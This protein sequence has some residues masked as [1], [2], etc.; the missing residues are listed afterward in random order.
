MMLIDYFILWVHIMV[1]YVFQSFFMRSHS[2]LFGQINLC[3]KI[4]NWNWIYKISIT[5]IYIQN[6][7]RS[8]ILIN[9]TP[10]NGLYNK[11]NF[12]KQANNQIQARVLKKDFAKYNLEGEDPGLDDD[13]DNGWKI[14]HSDV[15]RSLFALL[16][17]SYIVWLIG[18]YIDIYTLSNWLIGRSMFLCIRI[19]VLMLRMIIT[20]SQ[21]TRVCFA[22]F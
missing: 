20:G 4:N 12:T 11:Y 22:L 6:K 7:F 2:F 9:K 8:S 17:D 14:L 15:F 3:R 18:R 13:D 19:F 21:G 1:L 16:L 5:K 10:L